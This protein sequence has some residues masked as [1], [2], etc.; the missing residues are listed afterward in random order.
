MKISFAE[1]EPPRS[2]AVAVGVWEGGAL[3]L[4]ARQ[5][6]EASGGAI[7]RALAASPRFR[8]KRGEIVPVV[9]PA[10]LG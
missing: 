4:P 1:F 9:G 8:G 6:D 10:N 7:T 3:T 5:L 2:G